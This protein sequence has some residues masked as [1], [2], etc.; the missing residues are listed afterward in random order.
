MCGR[1]GKK[2]VVGSLQGPTSKKCLGGPQNGVKNAL[3][4]KGGFCPLQVRGERGGGGSEKKVTLKSRVVFTPFSEFGVK[5][6]PSGSVSYLNRSGAFFPPQ[7]N[8]LPPSHF[9]GPN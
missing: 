5:F 7:E 9:L 2:S 3:T 4:P 8:P 6:D 1:T